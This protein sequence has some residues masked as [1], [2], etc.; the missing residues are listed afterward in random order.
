MDERISDAQDSIVGYVQHR[1][2]LEKIRLDRLSSQIPI[3]FSVDEPHSLVERAGCG[4]QVEA[5]NPQQVSS[6]LSTLAQ[7]GR[8]A[9]SEMGARGRAY[10][11]AHLEYHTLAQ[12]F[13][14][15]ITP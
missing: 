7:M 3:L 13:I 8:E 10:A 2:Q 5:E 11:L 12:Q 15:E 1:M 4:I 14:D 6:A 9:R